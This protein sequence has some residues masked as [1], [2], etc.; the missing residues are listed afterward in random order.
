MNSLVFSDVSLGYQLPP[1][2]KEIDQE[3]ITRNAVASLDFNPIHTNPQW[4]K[5]VNLLGKGT[6]IA[7]GLCTVSF[8]VSVVTDW[9]YSQGGRLLHIDSKFI[10]P[11]R[12][13]DTITCE[14]EVVSL[15]PRVNTQEFVTVKLT[16]KSQTGELV[17]VADAKVALASG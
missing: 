2:V 5:E 15:H 14:G 17:A 13:G 4:A 16:A 7:H 11:V 1:I 10:V 8:M 12:P 3:V 9:C 6:T